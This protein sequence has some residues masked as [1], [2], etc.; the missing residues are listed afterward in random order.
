MASLRNNENGS[1][2]RHGRPRQ[3]IV[4]DSMPQ[5]AAGSDYQARRTHSA[6]GQDNDTPG[7]A[8]L[9]DTVSHNDKSKSIDSQGEAASR[10]E[11]ATDH[12]M[13]IS[14][15]APG[16]SAAKNGI[17]VPPIQMVGTPLESVEVV[18]QVHTC[19]S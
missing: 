13:I 7:G 14:C 8:R 17:M 19:F 2:P 10:R 12:P 6:D 1:R 11:D 15:I 5:L 3:R 16:L 4:N 9:L 18:D